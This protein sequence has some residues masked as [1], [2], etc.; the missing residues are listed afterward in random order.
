MKEKIILLISSL[1]SIS[2]FWIFSIIVKKD[3]L[4][5]FDFDLTVIIQDHIPKSIDA[6]LSTLSLIGSFEILGLILIAVLLLRKKP[7]GF[8]ILVIFMIAHLIEILGKAFITHPGPPFLFARY[9]FSFVF[10]TSYVQPGF[11]YPSGH[12]LRIVFLAVILLYIIII[13]KKLSQNRKYFYNFCIVLF[14]FL[15]LLT[16][17]SLGEHWT[18]DVIG[19]SLLGLGF[20]LLS[21]IFI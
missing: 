10:P 3:I 15:M 6:F 1:I 16:R 18:T 5:S 11:S 4:T 13:S 20:G 17:V 7:S 12:S 2:F 21:L 19:G 8:L 9:S 14:T